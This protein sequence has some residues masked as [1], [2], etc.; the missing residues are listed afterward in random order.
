MRGNSGLLANQKVLLT[1]L[2]E[3][4][5]EPTSRPYALCW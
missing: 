3:D 5:R 1:C 2:A 4:F